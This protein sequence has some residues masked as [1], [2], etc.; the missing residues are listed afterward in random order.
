MTAPDSCDTTNP[1]TCAGAIPA[2]V[3]LRDR[4]IVIAGLANEVDAPAQADTR[5][6]A[7]FGP[8]PTTTSINPAV[9][10]ASESHCGRPVRS[11]TDA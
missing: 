4:A 11:C 5:Q 7:P 8:D 10:M 3:L 9:A 2:N 6:A 1:V